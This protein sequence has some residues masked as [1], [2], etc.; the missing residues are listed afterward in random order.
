MT[1]KGTVIARNVL[2]DEAILKSFAANRLLHLDKKDVEIHKD[3]HHL[4]LKPSPKTVLQTETTTTA[5]TS[6][7]TTKAKSSSI[8]FEKILFGILN[9][10]FVRGFGFFT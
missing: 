9:W 5:T 3:V 1:D 2:C 10:I 7:T 4:Y 8:V 6:S